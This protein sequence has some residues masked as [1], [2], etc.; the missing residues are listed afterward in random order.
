M[1]DHPKFAEIVLSVCEFTFEEMLF[2]EVMMSDDQNYVSSK[3]EIILSINVESPINHRLCLVMPKTMIFEMADMLYAGSMEISDDILIDFVAELLNTFTGR[4]VSELFP[5][6]K[7]TFL[8]IPKHEEKIPFDM[9][10]C[11]LLALEVE[12]EKLYFIAE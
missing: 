10:K 7:N 2:Y 12:G 5:D 8:S 11:R 6:E 9:S 1:F 3:E 4:I